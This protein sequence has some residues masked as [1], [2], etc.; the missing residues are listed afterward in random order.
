PKNLLPGRCASAATA[1]TKTM[2][3]AAASA[4]QDL[5]SREYH[6][7]SPQGALSKRARERGA[8]PLTRKGTFVAQKAFD[9]SQVRLGM[10]RLVFVG[11]LRL[12]IDP[13]HLLYILYIPEHALD[14]VRH[15]LDAPILLHE[16]ERLLRADTFDSV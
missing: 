3:A 8:D 6:P 13:S 1:A 5:T 2:T 14:V 15:R 9:R 12:E 16:S 4:R 10:C 11:H 7:R